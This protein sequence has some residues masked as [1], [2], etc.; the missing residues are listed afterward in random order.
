MPVS[1]PTKPEPV[2]VIQLPETPLGGLME[3][4]GVAASTESG[5]ATY[6]SRPKASAITISRTIIRLSAFSSYPQAFITATGSRKP[7]SRFS[8]LVT[9]GGENGNSLRWES[10][11]LL[12]RILYNFC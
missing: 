8:K 6:A 9:P 10:I 7:F 3:I 11:L 2:T 4:A 12:T 5:L 1:L